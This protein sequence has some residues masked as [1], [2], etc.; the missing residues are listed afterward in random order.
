MN[1]ARG[2]NP[3]AT[4]GVIALVAVLALIVSMVPARTVYAQTVPASDRIV[5]V[6]QAQAVGDH[7]VTGNAL[8]ALTAAL[9]QRLVAYNVSD[10]R[11]QT[12][13]SDQIVADIPNT[14]SAL[15]LLATLGHVGLCE[16]V[17]SDRQLV[18]RSLVT[19]ALG[20]PESVGTATTD[21]ITPVYPTILQSTDFS[22]AVIETLQ[23]YSPNLA[24]L[25]T[26]SDA[27]TPGFGAYT[28][29]HIGQ[30]ISVIV[31]K[32]VLTSATIVGRIDGK[33]VIEGLGTDDLRALVAFL[34]S[35]PL[36]V[37]LALIDTHSP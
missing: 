26:L 20:G 32:R 37:P 29:S 16:F 34:R 1:D 12:Q 3:P 4:C 9:R 11:V 15:R 30:Y 13:G 25:L 5:A 21:T 36:I 17:G 7:V 31:D 24:I 22:D 35:G 6:Y 33:A 14:P 28:N 18:E 2:P 8:V 10:F 27:A 23:P 19:T